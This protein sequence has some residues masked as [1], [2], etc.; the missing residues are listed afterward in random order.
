MESAKNFL[1]STNQLGQIFEKGQ[2]YFLKKQKSRHATS[3]KMS[4]NDFIYSLYLT[5]KFFVIDKT[6]FEKRVYHY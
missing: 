2:K 6:I 5:K 1:P 3:K 4:Y